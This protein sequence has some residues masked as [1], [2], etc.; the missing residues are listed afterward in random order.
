MASA[1]RK[2]SRKR[3]RRQSRMGKKRKALIKKTG[4]TR[5]PNELFQ[6]KK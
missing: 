2:T 5:S 1:T 3:N 6:D 4:T